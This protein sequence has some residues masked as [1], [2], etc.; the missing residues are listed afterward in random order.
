MGFPGANTTTDHRNLFLSDEQ[1]DAI[2]AKEAKERDPI[3]Q[4]LGNPVK[5]PGR[6]LS[7]AIADQTAVLALASHKA[8]VANLTTKECQKQQQVKH[9]G[10]VTAVALLSE[11][12]TVGGSRIAL[13]ASWDK[14]VKV[15]CVDQPTRV[16][17]VLAG[18]ADFVKCMAAHPTLPM[19]YTGSAD[20]SVMIWKLPETLFTDAA[21]ES[22]VEISPFKTIKG[23]HT[24]QIYAI[25]L[26]STGSVLYSTGSDASIRAWDASTGQAA[27][28]DN[29]IWEIERGHHKTNVFDIKVSEN[30]LWTAS[31]DK[32]AVGWDMDTRKPDITMQHKA[33]VTSVLPVM[34]AGVVIT[35]TR[36]GDISV[37]RVS[38][39]APE[40]IREIHAHSDD[41]VCLRQQ[42]RL[43]YSSSLDETLRVWDIKEVI[44]FKG[45]MSYVPPEL[46]ALR[47]QQKKAAETMLTEDEERELAELMDGL[48]EL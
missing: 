4:K 5:A 42:G 24:G 26:D 19:V 8:A 6:I 21:A 40:L 27:K 39:G 3:R 13:S 37:W 10:P 45:G 25:A 48:D 33:F 9:T 14:T 35:G 18:H 29:E 17:A 34:Q 1:I 7:F 2:Q 16:V 32:T 28:V 15:W 31:A 12:Y 11:K 44:D 20:K 47:Q 41:V 46:A 36:G 43:F 38:A 23:D 30:M 22:P